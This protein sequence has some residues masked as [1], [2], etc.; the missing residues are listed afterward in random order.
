[1]MPIG[2]SSGIQTCWSDG[3]AKSTL[4][5]FPFAKR[6]SRLETP[7][8]MYLR[9]SYK[10]YGTYPEVSMDPN[11]LPSGLTPSCP[12]RTTLEMLGGKWRLLVLHQLAAGPLRFGELRRQLPDISEKVLVQE[13]KH[14]ATSNLLVR[15]SHGE[16]P[17][18]VEYHLTALGREALP[19]LAATAAFGSA[20]AKYLQAG[21]AQPLEKQP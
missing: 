16:V 17:P 10:L 14:L 21:R 9:K 11:A 1:M 18:R 12:I 6:P 19:L 7:K 8:G 3:K 13:L 2:P 4:L 20:Y 5:I 15:T